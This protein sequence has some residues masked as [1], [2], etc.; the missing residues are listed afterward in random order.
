MDRKYKHKNNKQINQW[1][2]Q[3]VARAWRKRKPTEKIPG[4][5][6][7]LLGVWS[8]IPSGRRMCS[9]G[10]RPW[11][12]RIFQTGAVPSANAPRW[13]KHR[14]AQETTGSCVTGRCDWGREWHGRKSEQAGLAGLLKGL[15]VFLLKLDAMK[16][17][18]HQQHHQYIEH[19]LCARHVQREELKI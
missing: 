4:W 19:F 11:G 6:S 12:R 14:N 9:T 7:W 18:K 15:C 5:A 8:D 16:E 3:S 13:V 1:N 10:H 17:F 2:H